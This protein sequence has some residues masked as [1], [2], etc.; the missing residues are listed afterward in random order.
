MIK[1]FKTHPSKCRHKFDVFQSKKENEII[2]NS[3]SCKT[4]SITNRI[5]KEAKWM[6]WEKQSCEEDNQTDFFHKNCIEEK[7]KKRRN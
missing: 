4:N 2:K 6:K 1:C 5:F 3:L 7:K